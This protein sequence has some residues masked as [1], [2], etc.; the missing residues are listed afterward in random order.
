MKKTIIFICLLMFS[1]ILF[2]PTIF[3]FAQNKNES[4]F[5]KEPTSSNLIYVDKNVSNN[6]I[7]E[8]VTLVKLAQ[9]QTEE[10]KFELPFNFEEGEYLKIN[11]DEEGNLVN[12]ANIYDVNGNSI[13]IISFENSGNI[14][15]T[16]K[17]GE[18]L[19]IHSTSQQDS[20]EITYL[21]ASYSYDDYFYSSDWIKRDGII[22]LSIFPK[23]LLWE[24][25]IFEWTS[26][27]KD[28]WQKL[29]DRHINDDEFY[30]QNG[31]KDQYNCH[32]DFAKGSKI[33]W[34]IEPSRPDVGYIETVLNGCNP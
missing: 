8:T 33:P 4:N 32:F 12:S 7:T 23:P 1:T 22:S 2:T 24:S 9:D 20:V 34:N 18:S 11:R 16:E 5:F 13:G 25:G 26:I 15:L 21:I 19:E 28:S 3:V 29:L 17:N 27:R 31:M 10:L 14:R 6:E 30:N